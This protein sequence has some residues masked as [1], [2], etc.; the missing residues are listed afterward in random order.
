[1][2]STPSPA[3]TSNGKRSTLVEIPVAQSTINQSFFLNRFITG[4]NLSRSTTPLTNA[5][6][7]TAGNISSHLETVFHF[8]KRF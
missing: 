3:P 6:H 4:A 2:K 1:L 7:E 5:V 8:C